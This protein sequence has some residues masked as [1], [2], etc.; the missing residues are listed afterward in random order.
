MSRI[1]GLAAGQMR[2]DIAAAL[3]GFGGQDRGKLPS[4]WDR[5]PRIAVRLG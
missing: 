4:S 1:S 5:L 3:L 2:V